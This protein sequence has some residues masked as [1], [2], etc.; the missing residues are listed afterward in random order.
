VATQ[1]E[2][3]HHTLS[4]TPS[5]CS[6]SRHPRTTHSLRASLPQFSFFLFGQ[7]CPLYCPYYRYF[8]FLEKAQA[9]LSWSITGYDSTHLPPSTVLDSLLPSTTPPI[10]LLFIQSNRTS[11]APPQE[12]S[13]SLTTTLFFSLLLLS[14]ALISWTTPHSFAPPAYTDTRATQTHAHPNHPRLQLSAI[15]R[16]EKGRAQR[17]CR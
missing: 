2:Q 4:F 8:V 10:R 13:L 3:A 17:T 16:E 9:G 15:A 12:T 6:S 5:P 11:V 14:F 7:S 1:R